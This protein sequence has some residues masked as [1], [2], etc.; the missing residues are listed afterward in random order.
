MA[1][2]YVGADSTR[3]RL[4]TGQDL[5]GAATMRIYYK[6]PD[7]TSTGF[8][9]ALQDATYD[10]RLYYEVLVTDLDQAGKWTFQSWVSMGGWSDYGEECYLKVHTP[11]V[12]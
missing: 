2:V 9:T 8:W 12:L 10:T 11:D 1:K 5:T 7:L 6:K 4:E 3:I